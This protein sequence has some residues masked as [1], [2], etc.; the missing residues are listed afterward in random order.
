MLTVNWKE[1]K[2]DVLSRVISGL[3]DKIKDLENENESLKKEKS[4]TGCTIGCTHFLVDIAL[5]L[6]IVMLW[7]IIGM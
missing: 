1:I 6:V 4:S 7:K 3:L 2:D 5:V